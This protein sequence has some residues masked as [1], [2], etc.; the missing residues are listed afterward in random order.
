[1]IQSVLTERQ[2]K[3]LLFLGLAKEI[4]GKTK[5]QKLIFLGKTEHQL[6]MDFEFNKYN[7]GPYSFSL[8]D[9]LNVLQSLE[10]I[11][12][13]TEYFDSND[14]F[15]GKVHKYSLSVKGKEYVAKIKSMNLKFIESSKEVISKWNSKPLGN[16]IK[17]VYSKYM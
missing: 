11:S 12:V 6:P 14:Q 9:E 8:S 3:L 15:E 10:L 1:M 7:Y 17:H 13:K 16:I 4:E 5:L 2:E